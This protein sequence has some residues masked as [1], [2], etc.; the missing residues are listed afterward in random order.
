MNHAPRGT[1]REGPAAA[2]VAVGT[3][4]DLPRDGVATLTRAIDAAAAYTGMVFGAGVVLGAIR[5]PLLVPRLGTRTAELLEMPLM[6]VAIVL[7]AFY[8]VRRFALPQAILVRLFMGLLAL[9]LMLLAELIV[10]VALRGES[11]EQYVLER[12]PVSGVVYIA[13]LGLFAAM[14]LFPSP[15]R[16]R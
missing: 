2:P 6:L 12:D 5:V 13:M 14:P 11:V 10:V 7:A 3:D 1:R 16:S 4:D 15:A 9:A 8:V